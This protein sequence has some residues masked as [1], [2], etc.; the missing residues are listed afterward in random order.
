MQWDDARSVFETEAW[1]SRYPE[2]DSITHPGI[3]KAIGLWVRRGVLDWRTAHSA[4]EDLLIVELPVVGGRFIELLQPLE[5][6]AET[7]LA[8]D[9]TLALV[10]VPTNAMRE[11][12]T[13]IRAQTFRNPRNELEAREAPIHIVEADWAEA[14]KLYISW[15][16]ISDPSTVNPVYEEAVCQSVFEHICRFRPLNVLT[17]DREYPTT[18]STYER[19]TPTQSFTATADE[20]KEAY[21][22]LQDLYPGN[23]AAKAADNWAEY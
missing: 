6:E 20:V 1:L 15:N 23:E 21:A 3:R 22:R 9:E 16:N 10:P 11:V 19:P 14:R 4:P 12:I 17:I 5:D 7:L 18:G 13:G 2:V 8:S